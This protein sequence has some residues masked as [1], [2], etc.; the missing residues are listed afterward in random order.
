MP[1]IDVARANPLSFKG[2][3]RIEFKII[4]TIKARNDTFAGVVV[5]FKAKKQDCKTLVEP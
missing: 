3:I 5:S 4:F 2:N 1:D